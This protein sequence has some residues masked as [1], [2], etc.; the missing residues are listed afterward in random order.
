MKRHIKRLI[1]CTLAVVM[2]ITLLPAQEMT[3]GA[4][5]TS[6]II[7]TDAKYVRVSNY[8]TDRTSVIN[9]NWKFYL[10]NSAAAMEENFNDSSWETIDLPHDFSITQKFTTAGEAESG[11]LPGGTGW[12]RKKFI[13]PNWQHLRKS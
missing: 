7:F 13:L 10:G 11:F 9:D 2:G 5:E 3:A 8:G 12:Y 1:A 4:A 6:G